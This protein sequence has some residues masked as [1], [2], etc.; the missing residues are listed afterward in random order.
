MQ[1]KRR[2]TASMPL[3]YAAT[4]TKIASQLDLKTRLLDAVQAV[5]DKI[6][7]ANLGTALWE[8]EVVGL[9]RQR[10]AKGLT[11]P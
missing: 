11:P 6:P 8:G 9:L 7:A 4:E 1:C 3:V 2:R 10:V 5:L